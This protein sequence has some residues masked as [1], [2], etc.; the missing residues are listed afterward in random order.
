MPATVT[1]AA[2]I[3]MDVLILNILDISQVAC[4]EREHGRE[5]TEAGRRGHGAVRAWERESM[6]ENARSP[7]S[8]SSRLGT[9]AI[10]R[11]EGE[12]VGL[13]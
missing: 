9:I 12:A 8:H 1:T 11:G 13:P 4:A 3:F 10:Q 6:G 2:A 7:P 5:G